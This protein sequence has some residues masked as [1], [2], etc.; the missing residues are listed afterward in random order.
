VLKSARRRISR[1][2]Y[3]KQS[4]CLGLAAGLGLLHSACG[5]HAA[6]SSL[7]CT[8]ASG[9]NAEEMKARD[10]LKYVDRSPDPSKTCKNCQLFEK[11]A[12]TGRCGGCALAKGPYHPDGYCIAWVG[13]TS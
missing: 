11:P 6:S 13:L 1:R 7:T 2:E 9:L 5:S 10:A 8:D 12:E 3:L 4:G